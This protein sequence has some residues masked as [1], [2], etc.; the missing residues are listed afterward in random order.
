MF[1]VVK[2]NGETAEFI[3]TKINDAIMKAFNATDVQYNNDIVDLLALRVT[4]DF[5]E[6]VKDGQIHVEDIQDSVE[7]ILEQSGY[8][9]AAKAFILYR[10]Q[11]E[12]MRTMKSTILDYKDVVNNY[13]KVEDWRVKENSTVTY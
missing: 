6:K 10:K 1:Q 11:R 13:V 4:A 8:A 5:Q 3:L 7:K 12:K 9:E 2:R